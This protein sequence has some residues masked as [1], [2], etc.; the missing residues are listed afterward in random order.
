MNPLIQF[1]TTPLLLITVALLVLRAFTESAG[2]PAGAAP[3]GG[4]P[5]DQHGGGRKRTVQR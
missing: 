4:Y 3:D 1:K 5:A 2:A